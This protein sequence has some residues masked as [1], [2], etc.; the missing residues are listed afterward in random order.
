SPEYRSELDM[1]WA[2]ARKGYEE[3]LT[4][5]VIDAT[6]TVDFTQ[7]D[8]A[9]WPAISGDHSC[10]P[11]NLLYNV[12]ET[13]WILEVANIAAELKIAL[14]DSRNRSELINA[15]R[16][17]DIKF[18]RADPE[19]AT[20]AGSNNVHFLLA[21]PDA[22]TDAEFYLT[23]CLIE[24]AELNAI[25]AY[26]WFHDSALMKAARY[27]AGNLSPAE[28]SALI[29]SAL[30]DEAFALHFLE[31]VFAAGH[32]AGTW[33]NAS[34]RKGTHDYYNEHGLEVVTWDGQRMIITGDAYMRKR[35][36]EIAA[37]VV[38]LS[39]EQFL[40]A[41]RGNI[42]LDYKIDSLTYENLPDSFN[43]CKNNY[44]ITR[45]YDPNVIPLMEDVLIQTP[46]PG[47]AGGLGEL[48]RFKA[49][50]GLFLGIATDLRTNGLDG[51]FGENQTLAGAVGGLDL[52]VRFGLGI[53]GVLNESGDG[54]V[55]LQI[56]WRQD[57]PSTMNY[58]NA[59]SQ[60]Q[61][62]QIASAIP[63]RDAYN[64]G[65]RMPFYLLP[66]DL[67]ITAPILVW[68]APDA[69][70]SMA[71]TAGNGGLIPWQAGIATSFGRFQFI[72]GREISVS[73]YGNGKDQDAIIVQEN[74]ASSLL[75][76]KSVQLDF[77]VVEYRPFRT[78]SLDQSS[79]LRVYFS[80]GVDFP[81][82]SQVILPEGGTLPELKPIWNIGLTAEFDWRYY[83]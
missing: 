23:V 5:T 21:R 76:Y 38:Q 3:R 34:Q 45:D 14:A 80:F 4:V 25:G 65:L 67:L 59:P 39:I 47:L 10:S 1:L 55:F 13:E 60:I 42:K 6:Q 73:L 46:V 7:L 63:G 43:V 54:L 35:D 72:L 66:F 56:G 31:D 15:L 69:F 68:A 9:A 41:S 79:S 82:D 33:G 29:L 75:T 30:A 64:L 24:G 28:Q 44:N 62:G 48:P 16:D 27:A 70:A 37:S 52:N 51:G 40:D 78:F 49:E 71:V 12:L 61:S 17:S 32:T 20:R 8:Y 2:E 26:S 74:N 83:L 57:S 18:Q 36:E 53:D 22:N 81:Y 77:P 19:Y 11:K 58:G 50:L